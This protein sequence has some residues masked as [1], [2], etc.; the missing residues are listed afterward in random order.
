MFNEFGLHPLERHSL[1]IRLNNSLLNVP[2]H[3]MLG[4]F[5][6]YLS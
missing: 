2:N 6:F 4:A 1:L 3:D 5:Y